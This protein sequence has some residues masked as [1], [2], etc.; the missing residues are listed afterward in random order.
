MKGPLLF[1]H[2]FCQT[3]KPHQYRQSIF[4]NTQMYALDFSLTSLCHNHYLL[5]SFEQSPREI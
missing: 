5:I 3:R 4:L 2:I 1:H